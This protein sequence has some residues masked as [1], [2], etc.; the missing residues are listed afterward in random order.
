MRRPRGNRGRARHRPTAPEPQM[1]DLPDPA[2]VGADNASTPDLGTPTPAGDPELAALVRG[3]PTPAGDPELAA[4]VR[5]EPTPAGDPSP[6]AVVNVEE[7]TGPATTRRGRSLKFR[8][9]A[10]FVLCVALALGVGVRVLY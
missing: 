1:T 6:S 2:A 8:F 10:S 9:G 5:G 7:T 3:E 4:L